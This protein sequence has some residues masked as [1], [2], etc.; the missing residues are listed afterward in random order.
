MLSF[1][2]TRCS[3]AKLHCQPRVFNQEA[4]VHSAVESWF[5]GFPGKCPDEAKRGRCS[6]SH[7][8]LVSVSSRAAA[9][10]CQPEALCQR[11]ESDWPRGE[12]KPHWYSLLLCLSFFFLYFLTR[13][14]FFPVL[15]A[16]PPSQSRNL[17]YSCV[18][19][20]AWY[21]MML[22][23]VLQCPIQMQPVVQLCLQQPC[24]RLPGQ[25][26]ALL[27]ENTPLTCF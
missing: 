13:P 4:E 24:M 1:G 27:V 20:A 16:Y 12:R 14:N 9:G 7:I 23:S 19:D 11:P 8:F 2:R 5:G 6:G 26:L 22:L 17:R 25:N 3:C 10:Q 15:C 18:N 21:H